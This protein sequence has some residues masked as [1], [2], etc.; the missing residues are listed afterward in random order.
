MKG[1]L[2]KF[3]DRTFWRFILVGIV[4]T[5]FGSGIM[6]VFYNVFHFGYWI[7]SASNYFFGSILS[8]ILN[9]SFTFKNHESVAKSGPR[10]VL[11]I[12]ICY[13]V[14]YGLAKPLVRTVLEG[15]SQ[16]IQDNVAM[17]AGMC[18]FVVL[19]YLGQ[20]LFVFRHKDED[21]TDK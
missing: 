15:A 21:N 9:R 20:R 11:N 8:Y 1:L 6:F 5:L 4:N 7:S 19:N 2:A 12:A 18:V 17:L 14:A 10:F 16:T 3:M 13:F